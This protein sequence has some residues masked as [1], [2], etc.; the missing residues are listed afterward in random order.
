MDHTHLLVFSAAYL[1]VLILPGP[2]VTALV[3]RVLARGTDGVTAF[4]GGFVVGSLAWFTIAATGL[5]VIASTF[6]AVFVAIR[7][8]GAAY[9]L[10]LGW[11]LWNAP[12]SAPATAPDARPAAPDGA[13]RLFLTGVAINLGNPKV[14]VFFLALLPTVVD[15]ATLTPLG[16]AELALAIAV[17]ASG[18]LT[19][20]ALAAARARR[21]LT[22]RRAVRLMNRGS[23]VVM[24]GAAITIAAK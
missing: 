24:A 6:A 1:A 9:L 19:A 16:F 20:Y 22:S 18:V 11:K 8:A 2:G 17:I 15:L 4:I 12:A 7:Y 5:A 10:Y 3:A 14:I 21:L 13:G 23:G